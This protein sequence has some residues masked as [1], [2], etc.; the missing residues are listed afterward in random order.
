MTPRNGH[1]R[2]AWPL[3]DDELDGEPADDERD[4]ATGEGGAIELPLT[5]D[6]I[7]EDD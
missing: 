1:D 6:D 3:D 7:A 2:G 5:P 4:L